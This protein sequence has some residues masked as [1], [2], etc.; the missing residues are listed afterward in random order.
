MFGDAATGPI[1]FNEFADR[2]P[3]RWSV[4]LSFDETIKE[5][6]EQLKKEDRP[7]IIRIRSHC[8]SQQKFKTTQEAVDYLQQHPATK[9]AVAKQREE[10]LAKSAEEKAAKE[11]AAAAAKAKADLCR[12]ALSATPSEVRAEWMF[13]D[14]ASGLLGFNE[15][16]HL[17]PLRW[18]GAKPVDE[19]MLQIEELIEKEVNRPIRVKTLGG[20]EVTLDNPQAAIDYVCGICPA[21][22]P[23][24]ENLAAAEQDAN[25]KAAELEAAKA[26]LEVVKEKVARAAAD[27]K[28]AEALH[29]TVN[30]PALPAPPDSP[31]RL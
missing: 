14:A 20:E 4:A 11:E 12:A 15:L 10:E 6:Q 23:L 27:L 26:E 18:S 16:A 3:L 17:N 24:W 2:N 21:K 9:A 13:A 29:E 8:V 25:M 31:S 1:G 5:L 22:K 28:A 19:I 30:L 7:I